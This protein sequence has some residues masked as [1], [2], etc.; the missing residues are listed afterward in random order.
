[1]NSILKI[2]LS[3]LKKFVIMETL[4]RIFLARIA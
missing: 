2:W 4:D 1:M 3:R